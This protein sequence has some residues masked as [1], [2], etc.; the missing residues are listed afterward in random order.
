MLSEAELGSAPKAGLDPR[1]TI[2]PA[3]ASGLK[4]SV[5][6]E[7]TATEKRAREG[8]D[9][10]E[11]LAV[12]HDDFA[13]DRFYTWTTAEQAAKLCD[14]GPLLVAEAS[15]GGRPT[16]FNT[17]LAQLA[18]STDEVGE[19][20]RLLRDHPQLRRRRYAWVSGYATVLGLGPRGYGDEL[21]EVVL[22]PRSILA[23]FEPSAAQPLMFVDTRGEAVSLADV[24]AQPLRLAAVYHVRDHLQELQRGVAYREYVLCNPGMIQRWSLRTPAIAAALEREG[25]LL[26]DLTEGAFSRLPEQALAEP[27]MAVWPARAVLDRVA[28]WRASLAFDT[29][30]YQPSP[31]NLRRIKA[32]LA[33][34][35]VGGPPCGSEFSAPVKEPRADTG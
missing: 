28:L 15:T 35:R 20:A 22:D 24:L 14:G 2:E 18:S 12:Y 34:A 1:G 7:P 6:D 27:A 23:K 16:P 32:A 9:L 29:P 26:D 17:A 19:V 10:L 4:G 5:K 30:R 11:S 13:R 25:A 21:I 3:P 8:V 33:D 31:G